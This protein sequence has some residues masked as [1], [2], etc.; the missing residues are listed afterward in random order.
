MPGSSLTIAPFWL[1]VIFMLWN[2]ALAFAVTFTVTVV[3]WDV[4]MQ[5]PPASRCVV[6]GPSIAVASSSVTTAHPLLLV[7][8]RAVTARGSVRISFKDNA[9]AKSSARSGS[10]RRRLPVPLNSALATAGAIIGVDAS[11]IPPGGRVEGTMWT[12]I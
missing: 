6:L 3:F 9:Y 2:G 10:C 8:A 12:S 5:V 4:N 7:W 1:A 11:P